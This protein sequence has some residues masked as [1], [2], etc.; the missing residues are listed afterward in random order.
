MV[1]SRSAAKAIFS[2]DGREVFVAATCHLA[3]GK[4]DD[5][6]LLTGDNLTDI[7]GEMLQNFIRSCGELPA[8]VFG[9]TNM[10]HHSFID[11]G[12][13]DPVVLGMLFGTK[14]PA[15]IAKLSPA[16]EAHRNYLLRIGDGEKVADAE[17][18]RLQ[19]AHKSLE[20]LARVYDIG[21]PANPGQVNQ[22]AVQTL[23]RRTKELWR[24]SE[25]SGVNLVMPPESAHSCLFGG[26]I[27]HIFYKG[28]NLSIVDDS[29][30]IDEKNALCMIP[31]SSELKNIFE[32]IKASDHFPVMAD[33]ALSL[34]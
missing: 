11:A 2:L 30:T 4:F 18:K 9:D 16:Y 10:K 8:L 15:S 28:D 3:G 32:R 34:R 14:D 31:M 20:E 25:I 17:V 19:D 33:F 27:D 26:V 21:Y 22:E 23:I 6:W 1:P 13:Y 12:K 7:N 24:M 5:R 29:Y